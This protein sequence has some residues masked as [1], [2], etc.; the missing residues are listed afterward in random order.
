MKIIRLML[1]SLWILAIWTSFVS[2]GF[3]DSFIDSW[4]PSIRYCAEWAGCG[5]KEWIDAVKEGITDL[6]TER[7]ASEYI[8]DIITYL[9]TFISILSVIY[10]I[11]AGFQILTWSWD[12]EKVKKSKQ[13]IIYVMI[14]TI[15]IWLAW[16]ITKFILS[17]LNN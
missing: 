3:F 5:L 2:A 17:V 1:I 14:G 8:Q 4:S 7:T 15:V 11:Y 10:I 13:I 12:E 16:P 6:E 9:L